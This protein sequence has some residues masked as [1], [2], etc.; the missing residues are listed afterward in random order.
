MFFLRPPLSECNRGLF[1]FETDNVRHVY[2]RIS[3][4]TKRRIYYILFFR[5]IIGHRSSAPLRALLSPKEMRQHSGITNSFLDCR[6]LTRFA[7]RGRDSR[8]KTYK[9]FPARFLSSVIFSAKEGLDLMRVDEFRS[10]IH[11]NC[12]SRQDLFVRFLD[13]LT[14][15]FHQ[16]PSRDGF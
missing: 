4:A 1:R 14:E 15:L 8:G 11:I 3:F 16:L 12:V 10:L 5:G 2:V 6:Y 7:S 9:T 13:P